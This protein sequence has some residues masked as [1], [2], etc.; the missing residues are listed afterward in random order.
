MIDTAK[1]VYDNVIAPDAAY[2][3]NRITAYSDDLTTV[4]ESKVL[5]SFRAGMR[6]IGAVMTSA[7]TIG[8]AIV[9][10]DTTRQIA[11]F[12]ADMYFSKDT[13][14]AGN[15]MQATEIMS[16][17]LQNKVEYTRVLAAL[18]VEQKRMKIS[19]KDEEAKR[20]LDIDA[21]DVKWDLELF[22]F[23][24]NAMAGIQGGIV[25]KGE[26]RSAASQAIGGA[27]SGAAMGA[28]IGSAVPGVGTAVGAGVGAV[29]GIG[30]SF[31]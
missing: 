23:C 31:L 8:E 12:A 10:G 21:A 29:L 30:S 20:N 4:M 28:M 1:S 18:T 16:K 11:K 9:T 3:E 26:T 25:N 22:A 24:H 19:I 14:R 13:N 5:A 17:L 6:D 15:V 2:I 27:L 7:F